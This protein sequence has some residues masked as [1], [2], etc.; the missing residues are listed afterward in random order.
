MLFRS[1]VDA[2][3]SDKFTAWAAS[4]HNS[5]P[6]LDA[7]AY[8]DLAKPSEAVAPF[9][10]KAVAPDLFQNIVGPGMSSASMPANMTARVEIAR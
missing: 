1:V 6:T 9:T 10:Y 4:V 8:S 5:G 3:P 2:V 7:K